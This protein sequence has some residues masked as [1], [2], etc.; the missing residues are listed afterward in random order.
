MVV[1]NIRGGV[2]GPPSPTLAISLLVTMVMMSYGA[3]TVSYSN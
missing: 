2:S 1:A 3:Q